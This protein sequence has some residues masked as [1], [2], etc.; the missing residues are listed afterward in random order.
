MMR[1]LEAAPKTSKVQMVGRI[2]L[3]LML[4][5]TGLSHL[6]FARQEFQAQVPPWIPLK[7]D[8][9]VFLSGFVEITLGLSL[10]AL[11][12]YK[13]YVGLM[14]ALFFV[15]VFPGNIA[16]YTEHRAAFG[17]N[18]DTARLVR[19][20]FQPLLVAWAL[21]STGAWRSELPPRSVQQIESEWGDIMRSLGYELSCSKEALA[22]KPALA[23]S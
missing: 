20:F 5:C 21:W 13:A 11:Y 14:V 22:E 8:L 19:L 10:L 9:V 18:T 12:R 2:L 16:Q 6:T 7:P 17:L 4:V 23:R 1:T 3:G 15:A